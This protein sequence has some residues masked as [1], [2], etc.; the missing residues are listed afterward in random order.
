M[1]IVPEGGFGLT[2]WSMK[3]SD[4]FTDFIQLPTA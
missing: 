1:V 2:V 3:I 4:F